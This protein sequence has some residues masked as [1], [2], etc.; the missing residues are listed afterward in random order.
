MAYLRGL[1]GQAAE[2]QQVSEQLG[3]QRLL[4]LEVARDAVPTGVYTYTKIRRT[5]R[6]KIKHGKEQ[7]ERVW[8]TSILSRTHTIWLWRLLTGQ[9]VSAFGA[10]HRKRARTWAHGLFL[11]QDL[12]TLGSSVGQCAPHYYCFKTTPRHTR[13]TIKQSSTAGNRRK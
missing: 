1:D 5:S 11:L 2:N 6:P 8:G 12:C 7:Q 4:A 9:P 3:Y 10:K 13:Q